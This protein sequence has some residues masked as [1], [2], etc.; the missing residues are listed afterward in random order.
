MDNAE[1]LFPIVDADGH[2]LGRIARGEAHGGS[3]VLHPVVHLHVYNSRGELYLQRRPAWKDVQPGKWD[4]ACGG[5]MAYGETVE[6]AL[7]R[8]VSEELGIS[9]YEPTLLA[10]YVFDSKRECE[11]VWAFTT[12]YDGTIRPDADELDGGRFWTVE[13]IEDAI[14]KE[15]LT[16]NF[17]QE[18]ARLLR[19]YHV[20]EP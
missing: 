5:H 1:E 15:V 12:V 18:Y 4:T 20:A 14:G 13:E 17:E 3:R 16:P 2:V 9:D 7:R 11:L 10:H 19:G 8:E 6:Q